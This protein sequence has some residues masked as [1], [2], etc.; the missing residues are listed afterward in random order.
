MSRSI[1]LQRYAWKERLFPDYQPNPDLA[2]IIVIPSFK[3][4]QLLAALDSLN[5]CEEPKGGVLVLVVVNEDEQAAQEVITANDKCLESLHKYSSRYELLFSHQRLPSKKAG[6]GL[7]RKI[8]M[9]EAVKIFDCIGTDGIIVCFDADCLCEKNYLVEIERHYL[10]AK[11]KAG[12]VFYEHQLDGGNKEEIIQYETYLRYY[13]DALRYA[14]YPYAHQTLGSCITVR[15]SAYES[16]G[17]MNTRKAGEDFYFLNKVI[18]HGGFVEINTTTVYPSSRISDRVPFGT[19]KA[20]GELTN[21]ELP[22]LVYN[23]KSFED[24]KVFFSQAKL[25]WKSEPTEIPASVSEFLDGNADAEI[26][27][28]RNQTNSLS[29]FVKRFFHWFDAFKILKYIHFCRDH[30]Y[31]NIELKDAIIWLQ[32]EHPNIASTNMEIQLGKLRSLDRKGL[33]PNQRDF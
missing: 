15:S 17:G 4:S 29:S 19:G 16:H 24:L 2:L 13:I 31:E 5:Q 27:L 33:T 23:P 9:D 20:V 25:F 26:G 7:A 32:K 22:Y 10:N 12:I 11:T 6:V 18:P 8:G 3:E 30:R 21:T 28:I 1:Y 14:G